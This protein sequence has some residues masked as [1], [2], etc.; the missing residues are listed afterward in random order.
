VTETYP[1]KIGPAKLRSFTEIAPFQYVNTSP[2]R[3][4]FPVSA[5][6]RAIQYGVNIA[7]VDEFTQVTFFSV[8]GE[9]LIAP[10]QLFW[11]SSIAIRL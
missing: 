6:A 9:N 3:Y 1:F 11:S 10:D 4:G 7:R 2:I 8:S 5:R